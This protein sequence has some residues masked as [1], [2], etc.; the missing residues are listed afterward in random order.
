MAR[1]F[2]IVWIV[3]II[4][5]LVQPASVLGASKSNTYFTSEL[6]PGEGVPIFRAKVNIQVLQLPNE[7]SKPVVGF[8]LEKGTN[9]ESLKTQYQ[10]I[11]PGTK[12]IEEG[13]ALNVS[14]YGKIKYLSK[15]DYY[16][17][18]KQDTLHL[19]KGDKINVLQ[20]RAEGSLCF[21][22]QGSIYCGFCP[23]CNGARYETAWWVMIEQNSKTGW[24]LIEDNTVEIVD[25]AF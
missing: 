1:I 13:T 15:D 19:K 5:I 6:S 23:P 18:G 10:T 21:E 22:Y 17:S 25:H 20:S 9:F 11:K 16:F 2:S 14:N 24:V 7:G 12:I 3:G 4:V 8:V